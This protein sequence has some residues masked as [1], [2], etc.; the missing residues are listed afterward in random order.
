MSRIKDILWTAS[1]ISIGYLI[2][3]EVTEFILDC[4]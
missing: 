1:L 2:G 3:C 4:I